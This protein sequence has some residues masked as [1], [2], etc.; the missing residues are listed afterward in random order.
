MNF[1]RSYYNN[2]TGGSRGLRRASFQHQP[3][4]IGW[5]GKMDLTENAIFV[6]MP[7]TPKKPTNVYGIHKS[8]ARKMQTRC[9]YKLFCVASFNFASS[10]GLFRHICRLFFRFMCFLC[11]FYFGFQNSHE[12]SRAD[13]KIKRLIAC[14]Q[15]IQLTRSEAGLRKKMYIFD[16]KWVQNPEKTEKVVKTH[17]SRNTPSRKHIWQWI[18]SL[19]VLKFCDRPTNQ[20]MHVCFSQCCINSKPAEHF[21]WN[22]TGSEKI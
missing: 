8:N 6:K 18:I 10:R 20:H 12:Y 17:P 14:G 4:N 3:D 2:G 9:E 19:S 16:S 7:K 21:F 5:D 11:W 1:I 15:W 22:F 13:F